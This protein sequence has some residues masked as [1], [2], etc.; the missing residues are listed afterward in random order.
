M[1]IWRLIEATSIL[2]GLIYFIDIQTDGD[3]D[4]WHRTVKLNE[5]SKLYKFL[6][7]IITLIERL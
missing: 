1:D 2:M 7:K 4:L 6:M 3:I 5:N